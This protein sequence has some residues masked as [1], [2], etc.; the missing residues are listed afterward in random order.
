[1]KLKVILI[2]IFTLFSCISFAQ[3]LTLGELI[4]LNNYDIDQFD[5]YVTQ[6]GFSYFK[7]DKTK[8]S[9]Y[10]SYAFEQNGNDQK[11]FA[12]ITKFS[13]DPNPLNKKMISYQLSNSKIY[14]SIKRELAELGFKFIKIIPNEKGTFFEY[15]RGGLE[16]SL[17]SYQGINSTGELGTLYEI[18]L[19]EFLKNK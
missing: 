12:F 7:R 17:L 4:K 3:K 19:T 9:T 10:I 6:K 13:Y 8:L 18:S 15:K 1:M 14:Y 11:S 16:L 2:L 5:S